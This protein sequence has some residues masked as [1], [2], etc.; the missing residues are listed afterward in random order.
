MLSKGAMCY[1]LAGLLIG[2]GLITFFL[3]TAGEADPQWPEN[4]RV[5]P[6]LFTPMVGV[7]AGLFCYGF[8]AVL[9]RIGKAKTLITILAIL[10]SLP[11]IWIGL[12]LGLDG[13]YWN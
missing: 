4:W 1:T 7:F 6:L 8:R 2:L 9:L 12:I 13:T 5:K 10:V 11:I 3:L